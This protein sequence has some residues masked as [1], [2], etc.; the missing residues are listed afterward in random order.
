MGGA[1]VWQDRDTPT[2]SGLLLAAA[3]GCWLLRSWSV[4]WWLTAFA[5][6]G[7]IC[8]LLGG[9]QGLIDLW[10]PSVYFGLD[11][12]G[13]GR[14]QR[15][16][17]AQ[18]P[19]AEW[20]FADTRHQPA[21][22]VS[23]MATTFNCDGAAGGGGAAREYRVCSTMVGWS[24][25]GTL[26][27]GRL[28]RPAPWAPG[29]LGTFPVAGRCRVDGPRA[30]VRVFVAP[31]DVGRGSSNSSAADVSGA[32]LSA[33]PG[34]GVRLCRSRFLHLPSDQL[35]AA[36]AVGPGARA[37]W[38]TRRGE[39]EALM[40][41]AA[42]CPLLP[43]CRLATCCEESAP[44]PCAPFA[45]A[46]QS[47]FRLRRRQR[48]EA[49][50]TRAGRRF[51]EHVSL[52]YVRHG[53]RFRLRL[54]AGRRAPGALPAPTAG[55]D[56]GLPDAALVNLRAADQEGGSRFR[57]SA[58]QNVPASTRALT[59]LW[60]GLGSVLAGGVGAFALLTSLVDARPPCF[61]CPP[62]F[63]RLVWATWLWTAARGWPPGIVAFCAA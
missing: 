46:R 51:A 53:G 12:A 15:L 35:G 60:D 43:T 39:G 62:S 2:E 38:N 23:A 14:S 37:A 8:C 21:R 61:A 4:R 59:I 5:T 10:C 50:V 22:P 40:I 41:H 31:S 19:W 20:I 27:T 55:C 3:A 29:G 34:R 25:R 17:G 52:V 33:G 49:I 11:L 18:R 26:F 44:G 28:A 63:V 57:V 54:R 47:N 1:G 30:F 9:L 42:S 16:G 13:L 58:K 48:A 24:F 56:F 7:A 36:V 45:V 6:A 32:S